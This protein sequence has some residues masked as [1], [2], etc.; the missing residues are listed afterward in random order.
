MEKEGDQRE[1]QFK[2]VQWSL[3]RK[4]YNETHHFF[5][6]LKK[7]NKQMKPYKTDPEVT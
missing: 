4:R 7:Q 3:Y 6:Q 2:M 5:L 1:G